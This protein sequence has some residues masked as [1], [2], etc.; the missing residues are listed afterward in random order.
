MNAKAIYEAWRD[1]FDRAAKP[2]GA[3]STEERAPWQ[4][5]ALIA[6]TASGE[7]ELRAKI[8]IYADKIAS[9]LRAIATLE[10]E[11]SNEEPEG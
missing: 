9:D 1:H 7:M 11:E 2:W 5:I 8:L 3:M 6:L 10:S 4:T